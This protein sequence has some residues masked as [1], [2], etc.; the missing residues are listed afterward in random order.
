MPLLCG[1]VPCYN[2]SSHSTYLQHD[3]VY[4]VLCVHMYVC[5][6]ICIHVHMYYVRMY[7]RNRKDNGHIHIRMYVI[8]LISSP[9]YSEHGGQVCV[10]FLM[11]TCETVFQF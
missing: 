2:T 3:L 10:P 9:L 1:S 6:Y 4:I 7:V 8:M 5:M 11:H